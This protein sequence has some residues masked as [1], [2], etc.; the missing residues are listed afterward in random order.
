MK[1]LFV[2]C[3]FACL[4][5]T[6]TFAA[7]QKK[8]APKPASAKAE[9][10]RPSILYDFKGA[11]LGMTLA[12]V[13]A[14]PLPPEGNSSIY[15]SKYIKYGPQGFICSSD[16]Y[17]NGKQPSGFYLGETERVLGVV[18]CQYGRVS[19][20]TKDYASIHGSTIAIGGFVVSDVRYK[21]M[22]GRLYEISITGSKN[23][24]VDV[25]DGLNAKF[26][27]PDKVVED[28]TQN[29]AG[30]TF[31]HSTHTWKN[32]AASITVEAPWTRIDNMNVI[33]LSTEGANRLAAKSQELHPS[34]SKM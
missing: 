22:D 32:P 28:T 27:A 23:A 2:A 21:F 18:A 8:V 11:R 31:P 7:P 5:S 15:E 1:N 4:L 16:Q 20:V 26:G 13:K 17:A 14:L 10:V 33:F 9:P 25:L 19:A 24:L 6:Q 34:A 30:A 3:A 29:K 12:E